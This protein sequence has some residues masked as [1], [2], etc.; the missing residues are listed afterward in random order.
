MPRAAGLKPTG[1]GCAGVRPPCGARTELFPDV[2][3]RSQEPSN[4]P[5]Y[6]GRSGVRNRG[7]GLPGVQPLS[8]GSGPGQ[9]RRCPAPSRGAAG[10]GGGPPLRPPLPLPGCGVAGGGMLRPVVL[11]AG[12][13][14]LLYALLCVCVLSGPP[15]VAFDTAALR[16]AESAYE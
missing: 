16:W 13:V 5:T 9:G 1:P 7:G 3:Q 14:V 4:V 6:G 12:A 8:R 11:L 2:C 10:R 15:L